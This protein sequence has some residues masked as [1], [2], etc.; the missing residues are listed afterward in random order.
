MINK[1]KKREFH[2][3][4]IHSYDYF[5]LLT[6]LLFNL[7]SLLAVCTGLEPVT[8]AVT[9]QHSEPTELTHQM[10]YKGVALEIVLR[11]SLCSP[12]P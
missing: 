1:K 4:K 5:V 10:G 12:L 6:N 11:L 3:E 2:Y 7:L 9:G 8:S